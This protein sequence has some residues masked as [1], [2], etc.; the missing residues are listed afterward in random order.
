MTR[1]SLSVVDCHGCGACC[2][3]QAGLPVTW[4]LAIDRAGFEKLPASLQSELVARRDAWKATGLYPQD[5]TPCVWY[6]SLA[7]RCRNYEDRPQVCRDLEV[8]SDSCLQWRRVKGV[9]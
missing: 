1:K 9:T 7:K 3:E 8:G 5:G 6:D 2:T 4:Y